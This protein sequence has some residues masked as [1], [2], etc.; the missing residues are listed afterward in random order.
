M[1]YCGLLQTLGPDEDSVY[2]YNKTTAVVQLKKLLPK[3]NEREKLYAEIGILGDSLK[4]ASFPEVFK[5][6]ELIVH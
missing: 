5:I 6:L 1:P 3:A 4:E 2:K